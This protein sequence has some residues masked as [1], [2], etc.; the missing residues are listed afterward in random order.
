MTLVDKS[1]FKATPNFR[2]RR[3]RV[4]VRVRIEGTCGSTQDAMVQ[5]I[6]PT[7]VSA[8]ARQAPPAVDDVVSMMLPDCT[9]LWGVVRWTRGKHF[10]AEFDPASRESLA[11]SSLV[12]TVFKH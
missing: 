11:S 2:A 12:T 7:G 4:M 10:G 6:S 9:R 8:V 5:N 1:L 3:L